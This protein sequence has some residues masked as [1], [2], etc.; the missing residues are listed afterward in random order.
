MKVGLSRR[1]R[2]REQILNRSLSIIEQAFVLGSDKKDDDYDA[3]YK[4]GL[5]FC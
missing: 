2:A 4:D 1:A 3:F 5:N